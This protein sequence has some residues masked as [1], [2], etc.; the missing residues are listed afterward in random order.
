[1]STGT[2]TTVS[3]SSPKEITSPFPVIFAAINFEKGTNNQLSEGTWVCLD[4]FPNADEYYRLNKLYIKKSADNKTLTWYSGGTLGNNTG[5]KYETVCIGR[6]DNNKYPQRKEWLITNDSTWVVPYTG[7]YMVELYGGGGYGA[8]STYQDS[9]GY[10]VG[11]TAEGGSSCQSYNSLHLIKDSSQ[12][13]TI[14]KGAYKN[15]TRLVNATG[16]SFRSYS[17]AG[18]RNG[19]AYRFSASSAEA[20]GGAGAGNK[21]TTR[22]ATTQGPTDATYH[23]N[24]SNGI[25]AKRFG[26]SYGFSTDSDGGGSYKPAGDGAVYI[27]Y[28][29]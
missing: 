18:G 9:S 25:Y 14:G 26:Y 13:I 19:D 21:G 5:S 3:Q 17:V 24:Y 6:H 20:T 10:T 7:N 11:I 4:L 2:G 29:D 23:V 27:K 28:L 8:S 1:M 12:S 15:G 16:T 22:K